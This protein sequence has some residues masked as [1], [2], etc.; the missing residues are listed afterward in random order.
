LACVP[1]CKR[2]RAPIHFRCCE[3]TQEYER[4]QAAKAAAERAAAE[5]MAAEKAAKKA[6]AERAA[7]AAKAAAERAAAVV[8]V[9]EAAE[10]ASA[11]RAENWSVDA[12]AVAQFTK[13]FTDACAT[14]GS[15]VD[16]LGKAEA[17]AVLSLS[18]LPVLTLQQIWSLGD[19]DGDDQLD[20]KEFLLCCWLVQRSV[21]KQLPPPTALP[22]QLLESATAAVRK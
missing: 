7:A 4:Q 19:V 1:D 21:Q 2:N 18:G 17:G 11:E 6:A 3:C 14:Q 10:R 20:L 22:Q 12:A 9:R 5:K 8:A 13:L 16:R 15:G